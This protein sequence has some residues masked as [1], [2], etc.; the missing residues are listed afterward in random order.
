M[1][2]LEYHTVIFKGVDRTGKRLPSL[3][4]EEKNKLGEKGWRLVTVTE[5]LL[6][7]EDQ[8][9]EVKYHFM[10]PVE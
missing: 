7:W 3:S 5:T 2:P 6:P 8:V 9:F 10:R 1:Q 4:D